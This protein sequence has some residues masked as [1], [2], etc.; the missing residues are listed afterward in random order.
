MGGTFSAVTDQPWTGDACSLVEA[1]RAG[2]R[3]PS[4]ELAATLAAAEADS[5]NAWAHVDPSRAAVA[6]RAADVAMPFGGVPIGV[7]ELDAVE[8]WPW[9]EASVVF[10][11]RVA[12]HTSVMVERLQ[13]LGG[14]VLVGQT[15]ASEFGGVNLTRTRLHGASANPWAVDRTPGGSSGGSAAAVAG[16]NVTIATAATV[17]ARSASRPGSAG[18]SG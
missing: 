4:E 1:F 12:P 14:A 9:T 8:G 11:D 5:L 3:S 17:A 6:A 2:E 10:R 16:G 18:W 7:K 15:T 13:T